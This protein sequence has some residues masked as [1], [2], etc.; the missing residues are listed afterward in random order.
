[1]A[2]YNHE[3]YLSEAIEGVV[4]QQAD[5]PVELIIGDDSS[6]DRTGQI[7]SRYQQAYPGLIRVLRGDRNVGMHENGARLFAA[8]RGRYLAFCEGDDCWHRPD[9]LS[10][11]VE[12]LESDP[13]ISLVCSSWR[14]VSEQGSVLIDDVLEIDKGRVHVFGLDDI[15]AG[16]IKWVTVCTKAELV[17]RALKESPL[18]RPGRYPFGDAPM[19]VEASRRGRC[20]CLPEVYATYRLSRNSATRPRDIM[21]VYRFIAGS[22][23]F[24]RDALGM[25]PLPQGEQAAIEG[26]VRATRRRLRALARLGEAAK[27]QEEL[28][29]LRRL[30][31][32]AHVRDH[33]LYLASLLTQPGT[34][35]A[36]LRRWLLLAWNT[37]A[38]GRRKP[39]SCLRPNAVRAR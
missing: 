4:A 34:S 9:K 29:W 33:L 2:A 14:A 25:Y 26:R 24:D 15:L 5:F 38:W 20:V 23:E 8:A 31:V 6:M 18:C 13:E 1:M 17:R 16:R 36:T 22:C 32:R 37:L 39:L 12:L 11:Q 30:G 27:V 35:G 7:A 21:D 28:Q 19:C 3:R 10:A